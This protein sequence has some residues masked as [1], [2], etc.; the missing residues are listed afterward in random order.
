MYLLAGRGCQ[1][2]ADDL[3]AFIEFLPKMR[4]ALKGAKFHLEIFAATAIGQAV[5]KDGFRFTWTE[6]GETALARKRRRIQ[7]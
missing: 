7:N 2:S 6:P 4:E 3:G 1:P 5:V